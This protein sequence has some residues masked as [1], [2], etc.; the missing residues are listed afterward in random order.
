M[1][2]NIENELPKIRVLLRADKPKNAE[3]NYTLNYIVRFMG[4]SMK[5]P[6]GLYIS[7]KDWNKK[8]GEVIGTSKEILRIQGILSKKKADFNQYFLNF[9]ATGGT[10]SRKVIDDF[11]V[12]C[13]LYNKKRVKINFFDRKLTDTKINHS[14]YIRIRNYYSIY[15]KKN[16]II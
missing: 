7:S 4:K 10:I 1:R 9:D 3:G 14:H 15:Y 6:T 11:L 5:K 16:L 2:K 12:V 8:K 13:L